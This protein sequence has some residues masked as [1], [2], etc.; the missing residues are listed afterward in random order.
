ASASQSMS[1]AGDV[2]SLGMTLVETL[3][4]N[5]P[6]ERTAEQKDPL[7]PQS[8][9]EPFL[10]I[11]SHCLVRHA[12]GRWTV[13]QIAARL[14]EHAAMTQ[15]QAIPRKVVAASPGPGQ[16]PIAQ[17]SRLSVKLRK[18]AT[19]I[20]VVLTLVLA[21]ILEGPTLMRRHPDAPQVPAATV[22]PPLVPP[23]SR[24]VAP[25]PQE[26]PTKANRPS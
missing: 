8:L 18:Y 4:Q 20:A 2:W 21:A 26:R 17:P 6:V 22:E 14:Q 13:A 3:T 1:P 16:R 24:Q 23:A 5:L 15:V 11:A 9:Q 7:F 19:P 25:S 10:D 12:Y